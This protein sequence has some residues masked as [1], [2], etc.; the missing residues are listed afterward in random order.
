MRLHTRMIS[1]CFSAQI[2]KIIFELID[3]I[4]G[5]F[6]SIR[7]FFRY[8][9]P[10]SMDRCTFSNLDPRCLKWILDLVAITNHLADCSIWTGKKYAS[11][12]KM[13]SCSVTERRRSLPLFS[14]QLLF[15]PLLSCFLI[16]LCFLAKK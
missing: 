2:S 11:R 4:H 8:F 9:S 14:T 10:W 7:V 13:D 12:E 15:F 1:S 3:K 6:C 5:E 16:K